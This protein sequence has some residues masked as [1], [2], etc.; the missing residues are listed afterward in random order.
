VADD[1]VLDPPAW[2]SGSGSVLETETGAAFSSVLT[3]R[4]SA[5]QALDQAKSALQKL[6]DTP[7]PV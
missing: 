3:G 1:V 7:S 2:F 6:I 4:S 5:K